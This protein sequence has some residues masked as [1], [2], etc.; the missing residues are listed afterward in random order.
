MGIWV[1]H[2]ILS[3]HTRFIFVD[4]SIH[5]L[6]SVLLSFMHYLRNRLKSDVL[7]A[8]RIPNFET[9]KNCFQR[10]FQRNKN[11]F[12]LHLKPSKTHLGL[13]VRAPPLPILFITLRVE[14]FFATRVPSQWFV[15]YFLK[16][17]NHSLI[18]KKCEILVLIQETLCRPWGISKLNLKNPSTNFAK[19][20]RQ[21][22]NFLALILT[23]NFKW[24]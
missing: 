21:D 5:G 13:W 8:F 4:W 14:T 22:T 17:I 23:L 10:C 24:K 12:S 16:D 7:L 9:C 18:T 15:R 2:L 11:K 20:P 6:K 1:K 3:Q 19:K